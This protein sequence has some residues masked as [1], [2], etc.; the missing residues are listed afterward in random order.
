LGAKPEGPEVEYGWIEVGA[1][2]QG[3]HDLFRVRTFHEKPSLPLA[4]FLFERGSLWNT[5]VL[6]GKALAFMEMICSAIPG[7]LKAF[8]Q[9][10]ALRAPNE[11][12]RIH[13]SLYERLP[14]IDF[15]RQVLTVE[16]QRLIVQQLGPVAW[17]DLGDCDRVVAALSSSGQEPEWATRWRASKPPK[18]VSRP[19]AR[20]ALA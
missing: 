14:S 9:S 11:E 8:Q 1:S 15:S 12:L 19:A 13:A 10:P 6:V 16:T 20:A 7:V 2:A 5:F 17:S 4:R 18:S 3:R